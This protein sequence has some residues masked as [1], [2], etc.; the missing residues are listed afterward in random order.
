MKFTLKFKLD[1]E[2]EGVKEPI[3]SFIPG[4]DDESGAMINMT[5]NDSLVG[6]LW[7]S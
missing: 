1:T 4:Y 3:M 7:G 5:T 2:Q 6:L